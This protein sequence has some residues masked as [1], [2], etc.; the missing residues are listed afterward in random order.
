MSPATG[1]AAAE[2][3]D[4]GGRFQ[5]L[6]LGIFGFD[7]CRGLADPVFEAGIV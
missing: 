2:L 7:R 4:C 1:R 3:I 6:D 5:T